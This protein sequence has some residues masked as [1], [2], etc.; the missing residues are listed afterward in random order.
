MEYDFLG[1][2]YI[3]TTYEELFRALTSI[4]KQTLRPNKVVLVIDGPIKFN[5]DKI[6]LQFDNKLKIQIINLK[7]N[8]GLG[9]AL[10]KGLEVCVS[11][12]VLRFDTDD[13]NIPIRAARQIQFM[14]QGQYDISSTSIFEF[15]GN[16]DNIIAVKKLPINNF[17][18]KMMLP[19][20]NPFNHPSI[21]FKLN[22]IRNLD[23]GYRNFPFYEDYDL[24]IR[25]IYGGLKCAN[26]DENL[27]GMNSDQLIKRR[28][29]FEK[30]KNEWKLVKTF[31]NNSIFG[32]ILFIPSFILRAFIRCL[33]VFFIT[34][35]YK[36]FLRS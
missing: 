22:S 32:F 3:N 15:I 30:T 9:V 20:R 4:K 23:G 17:K 26:L 5:L 29:G 2:A 25:A 28:I 8:S 35:I 24:W 10:R 16:P 1:S 36:K 27:V 6:L 18:I 14:E 34:F 11:K 19:F 13:I 21:C 33:P 12:Y 31:R 7:K